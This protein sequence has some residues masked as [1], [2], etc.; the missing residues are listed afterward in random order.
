MRK[1]NRIF[2]TLIFKNILSLR[3]SVMLQSNRGFSLVELLV[4]IG[5]IG[6][7]AA[8]ALPRYANYKDKALTTSLKAQAK[9]FVK[10]LDICFVEYGKTTSCNSFS[11]LGIVCDT[12][13]SSTSYCDMSSGVDN[14]DNKICATFGRRASGYYAIG[15]EYDVNGGNP[16]YL[17]TKSSET[18]DVTCNNTTGSLTGPTLVESEWGK[19]K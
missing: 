17:Y 13:S 8:I 3:R 2:N 18:S 12:N 5:I 6:V 14:S 10:A 19:R 1:L 15:A 9:A 11:R 4:V 16:R 7:L